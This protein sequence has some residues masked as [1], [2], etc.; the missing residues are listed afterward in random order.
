[1]QSERRGQIKHVYVRRRAST[2]VDARDARLATDVDGLGV[3]GPL[4]SGLTFGRTIS[5]SLERCI[6]SFYLN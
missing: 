2:D 4:V 5:D 3:N 1:M 6:S